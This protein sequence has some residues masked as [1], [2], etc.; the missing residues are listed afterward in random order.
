MHYIRRNESVR[1][2]QVNHYVMRRI[3]LTT[4]AAGR[5]LNNVFVGAVAVNALAPG[6]TASHAV[7]RTPN[8][9]IGRRTL[10]Y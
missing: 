1:L 3:C 8:V 2:H 6:D 5:S 7:D 10:Y 9:P 4:M